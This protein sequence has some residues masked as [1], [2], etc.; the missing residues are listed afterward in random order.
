MNT[1]IC[2][3]ITYKRIGTSGPSSQQQMGICSIDCHEKKVILLDLK[4]DRT[5][6]GSPDAHG[7]SGLNAFDPLD[8][9]LTLLRV[10]EV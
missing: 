7:Q 5:E 2:K 10:Q 1:L 3:P 4:S 9:H 6:N 8:C